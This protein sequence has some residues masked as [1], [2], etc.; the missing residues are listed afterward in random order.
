MVSGS[1]ASVH[2]LELL[3][4]SGR[5]CGRETGAAGIEGVGAV[6]KPSRVCRRGMANCEGLLSRSSKEK[7]V[8]GS[9]RVVA[10]DGR[11]I[12]G[13]ERREG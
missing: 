4:R 3:D 8:V 2:V 10:V 12:E 9:G 6:L 1:S 7:R 11:R 5:F 13:D